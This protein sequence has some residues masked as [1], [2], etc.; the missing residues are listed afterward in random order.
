MEYLNPSI[1]DRD[2]SEFRSSARKIMLLHF[3]RLGDQLGERLVREAPLPLGVLDEILERDAIVAIKRARDFLL[4]A[5]TI[6]PDGTAVA[7]KMQ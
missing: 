6:V 3:N 7:D 1:S 2:P 4:N 5:T